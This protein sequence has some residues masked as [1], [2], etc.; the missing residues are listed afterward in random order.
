MPAL[1]D[2][3]RANQNRAFT[4]MPLNVLDIAAINELAYLTFDQA[5]AHQIFGQTSFTL[6]ELSCL[7]QG[8][9]HTSFYDHWFTK[10]RLEIF[11]AMQAAPRFADLRLSHYCNHIDADLERQFG[12]MLFSLP[13]LGHF[14]LV[15]RGTDD[16]VIGW[17]EDLKL[18]YLTEL[19]A[20][21]LAIAYLQHYLVSAQEPFMVTGH[22]K[23]GNLAL[24][25]LCA[26]QPQ[27]TALI[28][29]VYLFDAPGLPKPALQASSYRLLRPKL[30]IFRPELSIVGTVLYCDV[31]PTIVKSNAFGIFQ[32][33]TAS[34]Q[35]DLRGQFLTSQAAAPFSQRM[36]LALK[37]WMLTLS[38]Q[39]FK[40]MIDSLFDSLL[41]ND[42]KSLRSF[43]YNRKTLKQ[44]YQILAS[45][46][47]MDMTKKRVLWKSLRCLLKAY[48][49]IWRKDQLLALRAQLAFLTK[50]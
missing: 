43:G 24:Y 32:H 18:T 44:L 39:E 15:F 47:S 25:A 23:G 2:Y 30:R 29:A 31:R 49:H 16:S 46:S 45:L 36:E 17:K 38:H 14:Q 1:A 40:L 42:I 3:V 37:E 5:F 19:P 6:A 21:R 50:W 41:A 4:E 11:Y 8:Q 7:E 26:L 22:S 27:Q 10:G 12:A 28:S 33:K 9:E 20:H 35:V 34:W 13:Q 48:R